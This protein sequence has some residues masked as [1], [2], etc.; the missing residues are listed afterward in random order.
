MRIFTTTSEAY[1]GIMSEVLHTPQYVSSPRG[2]KCL[3]I[4]DMQ[5][6][7]LEPDSKPIVTKD[8]DRNKVIKDYTAKELEWYISGNTTASSAPSTF[9]NKLANPDG[10]INSNYGYLVLHDNSEGCR[11]ESDYP[12]GVDRTPYEWALE[13]LKKDKDSRQAI[14]RVNKPEHAWMGNKDFPC[15]LSVVVHIREDELHISVDQRSGDANFGLVYDIPWWCWLQEKMIIDLKS[16][17]PDLKKGSF[18]HLVHSFH[19]YDRDINRIK[20]MLGE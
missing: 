5:Y 6:R 15:T 8:E 1:L 14:M 13:T 20:K 16:T 12:W 3:E 17:Y 2:M 19:I 9:W 11:Y 7:V 10:T 4:L 18:T